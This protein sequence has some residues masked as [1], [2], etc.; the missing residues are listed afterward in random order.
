MPYRDPDVQRERVRALMREYNRR[1]EVKERKRLF[2]AAKR[3]RN[4]GYG[5][6]RRGGW[7][8]VGTRRV[9][10]EGRDG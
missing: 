2:Q 8:G 3:V 9:P 4:P 10:R 7:S 1:P 5:D 6:S